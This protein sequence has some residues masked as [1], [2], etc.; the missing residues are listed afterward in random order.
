MMKRRIASMQGWLTCVSPRLC[1]AKSQEKTVMMCR[2]LH[3]YTVLHIA[4]Q[5][6]TARHF[7]LRTWPQLIIPLGRRTLGL[8]DVVD[9][10]LTNGVDVNSLS[11]AGDTALI[12]AATN[13]H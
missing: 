7:K 11:V 3:E 4:C 13:G 8:P 6:G 10:A 12:L 2:D 9:W 5:N 1:F